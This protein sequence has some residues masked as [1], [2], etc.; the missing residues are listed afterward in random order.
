MNDDTPVHDTLIHDT[1]RTLAEAG[2]LPDEAAAWERTTTAIRTDEVRRRR[3]RLLAT[4]VGIATTAAAVAVVASFAG[5]ADQAVDVGPAS[6]TSAPEATATSDGTFDGDSQVGTPV[7]LPADPIAVVDLEGTA[8]HV[9]DATTGARAST[10]IGP[11]P[12]GTTVFDSSIALDGTVY[13]TV[14]DEGVGA[15]TVVR[16]RW[17]AVDEPEPVELPAL[18]G[19]SAS[20]GDATISHDGRTLALRI[21]R[22]RGDGSVDGSLGL[23][24]TTTGALREL[25]WP[26]GDRRGLLKGAGEFSFSP[27]GASLAF[28]N[29]HDTDGT[30]AFDG[31]VLDLD[32]ASLDDASLVSDELWDLTFTPDGGLLGRV[33]PTMSE[34]RLRYLAGGPDAGVPVLEGVLRLEATSGSIVAAT[35]E[36]WF[37]YGAEADRW[38][39]VPFG[40]WAG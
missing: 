32:A 16:T 21:M 24:D 25:T 17:D 39:E 4:G 33:G 3:I 18:S 9:L 14:L 19:P 13:A 2:S 28:V 31:F 36:R 29:I 26:A 27:D 35:E 8:V 6:P 15:V 38:D 5:S 11:L 20:Y 37:R 34:S 7:T 1:L 10:P 12:K 30:D 22:S 40:N 23:F